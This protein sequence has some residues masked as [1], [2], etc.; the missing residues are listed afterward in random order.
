MNTV[1]GLHMIDGYEIANMI[2]TKACNSVQ[3]YAR[4]FDFTECEGVE[5][6]LAFLDYVDTENGVDIYYCYGAD[7]YIFCETLNN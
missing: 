6:T 3:Q 2:E 7:H 1:I 4:L 5:Q